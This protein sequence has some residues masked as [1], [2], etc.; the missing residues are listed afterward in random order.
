MV[1]PFSKKPPLRQAANRAGSR[2]PANAENT[3]CNHN[4]FSLSKAIDCVHAYA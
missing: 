2:Y 1:H 4:I 3:V